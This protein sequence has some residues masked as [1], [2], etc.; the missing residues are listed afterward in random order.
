MESKRVILAGG[1]RLLRDLLRRA[2]QKNSGIETV[3]DLDSY[4]QLASVVTETGADY[5]FVII[6][7]GDELSENLKAELFSS[8]AE[9][10]IVGLWVDGSHLRLEWLAHEQKDFT[11]ST[12]DE[13]THF[14]LEELRGMGDRNNRSEH[15]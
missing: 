15:N 3:R 14:L 7:P 5:V 10:K 13:L 8:K 9:L 11:G 6:R 2:L 12:M 1:S 4:Q